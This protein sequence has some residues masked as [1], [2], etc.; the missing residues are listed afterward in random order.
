MTRKHVIVAAIAAA[1][2]YLLFFRGGDAP[3]LT[4]IK[5]I[6][7]LSDVPAG[8]QTVVRIELE[9]PEVDLDD[10]ELTW[11]VSD[12]SIVKQEG[13]TATWR[14]PWSPGRYDVGVAAAHGDT[15]QRQSAIVEVRLPSPGSATTR[16]AVRLGAI[17]DR[18][19]RAVHY[20]RKIAEYLPLASKEEV[21][22][23]NEAEERWQAMT[24]LGAVYLQAHRY[25]DA[26]A[27][28][29]R[30]RYMVIRGKRDYKKVAAMRGIAAFNLGDD[31]LAVDRILAGAEYSVGIARYYLAR[32]LEERGD[33]PGAIENYALAAAGHDN[34][35]AI[36]RKAWLEL[37]KLRDPARAAATL[38]DAST[39]HQREDI[40]ER[41]HRDPEMA[42][43]KECW[44]ASG[45]TMKEQ[46][47]WVVEVPP[48]PPVRR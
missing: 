40:L 5:L 20:E 9:P 14:V 19:T 39:Y 35:D 33:Y 44:E 23:S 37:E 28:Y 3:T 2:T 16:Q 15:V 48:L 45:L 27:L 11:R 46:A 38:A 8:H 30:M 18:A 32:I 17:E 6:V 22:S 29:D 21:A 42:R 26:A 25:E 10:V 24:E 12:G 7:P 4:G 36:I 41:L 13:L 47:G 1:A 43:L 31:D 34:L